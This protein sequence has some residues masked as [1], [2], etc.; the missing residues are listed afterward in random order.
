MLVCFPGSALVCGFVLPAGADAGRF[1]PRE[2]SG[3]IRNWPR[4]PG[5]VAMD[6]ASDSSNF[7]MVWHLGHFRPIIGH[8]GGGMNLLLLFLLL[9]LLLLLLLH[10]L[11]LLLLF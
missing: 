6:P 5:Q 7:M 9:L 8:L 11:L 2:A 4:H 1:G 3:G 10:L